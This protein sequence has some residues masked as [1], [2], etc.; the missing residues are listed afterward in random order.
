M[1][2]DIENLSINSL[3]MKAGSTPALWTYYNESNDVVTATSYFAVMGRFTIG[4]LISVMGA[5][6]TNSSL[7]RVSAV[8][9]NTE[10]ATATQLVASYQYASTPETSTAVSAFY[11]TLSVSG[12]EESLLVTTA[13]V[14]TN[15]YTVTDLT[16]NYITTDS[17]GLTDNM[18]CT[19]TTSDTAPAGLAGA[20]P[21]YTVS[22]SS[23]GTKCKLS[24]SLGGAAIDIT[25]VGTGV[26]TLSGSVNNF[27]LPDGANGQ[28]KVIKLK[29][30]GTLDAVVIPANLQD[31]TTITLGTA[32][33]FVSLVFANDTWNIIGNSG[34]VVA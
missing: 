12:E 23:D 24:A 14:I 17:K 9:S 25:D 20:T 19:V 11:D 10:Y 26:Q 30:D 4:D 1:A 29:T 28:R 18:V 6:Y 33:E 16:N 7:Y 2:F 32:L 5:D 3:N 21:Y 8:A 34:G 27:V 13:A 15:V 31:G 22:T